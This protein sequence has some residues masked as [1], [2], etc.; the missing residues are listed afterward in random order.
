MYGPEKSY[1]ASLNNDLVMNG[2][3]PKETPATQKPY[4]FPRICVAAVFIDQLKFQL[5]LMPRRRVYTR[6][7]D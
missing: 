5:F 6:V 1:I 2:R 4:I 7:R 3:E